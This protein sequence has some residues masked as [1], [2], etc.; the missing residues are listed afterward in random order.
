VIQLYYWRKHLP[1][2]TVYIGTFNGSQIPDMAFMGLRMVEEECKKAV[3]KWNRDPTNTD[4]LYEYIGIRNE[5]VQQ[6]EK[7]Q[8]NKRAPC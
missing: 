7:D 1:T 2:D 4:W 8:A 6:W 3:A 5:E